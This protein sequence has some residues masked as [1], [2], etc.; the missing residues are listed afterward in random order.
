METY[1]LGALT[2]KIYHSGFEFFNLLTLKAILEIKQKASLFKI[3]KKLIEAGVLLKIE[4]NKYLLKDSKIKDFALANFLYQPSYVSFESALN[5]YGI[6]SQFPYEITSITTKKSAKKEFQGK[7]FTYARIKKNL[8]FGYQK[9]E[10]YLIAYPE[11]A[12][13]DQL[14]FKSKGL[15]NV[16]LEEYDLSFLKISRLKEFLKKYPRTKQFNQALDLLNNYF[17]L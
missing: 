5:F 8:F 15:K 10:N 14:Y 16:N 9:I 2:K 3:I 12:L 6:L 1:N 13:L 7:I 11:K 17:S 4:K